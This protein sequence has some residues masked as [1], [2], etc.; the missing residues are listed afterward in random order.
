MRTGRKI[1]AA[2]A[3]LVA[4]AASGSGGAPLPAS[5]QTMAPYIWG[6]SNLGETCG[7][8]CYAGSNSGQYLCCGIYH[9]LR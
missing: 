4:A 7:S 5:A 8:Y 1:V 2:V 9:P 3:V 6:I